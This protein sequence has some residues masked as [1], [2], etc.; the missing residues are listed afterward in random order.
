MFN[1]RW[2][3]II[4]GSGLAVL[5]LVG[6]FTVMPVFAQGGGM[7]GGFGPGGMMGGPGYNGNYGPGMMGNSQGFSGTVPFG[8]GGM[9][10]N[11]FNGEGGFA[12]MMGGGMMVN[13]NNAFY[14]A[15]Q[16]LSIDEARTILQTYLASLNDPNLQVVDIMIFDN[17]AYAQI[18]EKDSGLGVLEVLVD[19]TTKTVYPE[20]GP[21]MM[22]NQKYGMMSGYGRYGM[23]GGMMGGFGFNGQAQPNTQPPALTVTPEQAVAAAQSYVDANFA[24]ANLTVDEHTDAFYGYYTL[25]VQRDGQTVGMLSVNGFTGAVWPHT[26]HGKF[27]EASME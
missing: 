17:H 1:K 22:W 19:P 6:L 26:W 23:M 25:H 5:L 18:V 15:P 10:G 20:M 21:T 27:L 9:M 8:P 16:P 3:S 4:A 7:M 14:I 13:P 2:F 24:A 12:G 11:F